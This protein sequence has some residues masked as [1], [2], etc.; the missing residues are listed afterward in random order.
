MAFEGL[1][2]KLRDQWLDLSSKIQESSAFNSARETFESQTPVV[3]KAIL[4]GSGMLFLLFM[5]S[6]PY[7]YIS[8]SNEYL[9]QF[10]ENRGLIQ[11]LL[12]ASR[13][14]KEP[15][16]LPSSSSTD[17][18]RSRVTAIARENQLVPEQIGE[19]QPLPEGHARDLAPPAVHEAGLAVQLKS[20]NLRQVLAVTVALQN[21]GPGTKLLGLDMIQS[22]D[23]THYYDIVARV[24]SFSLPQMSFESEPDRPKAGGRGRPPPKRNN[25]EVE[26]EE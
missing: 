13:A 8:Q 19:M 26:G 15:S 18:L 11:G 9:A 14:A 21:I 24:V 12:R 6:F 17:T 5:L 25:D 4:V 22:A 2:E 1:K 3:Q 16:P 20:L 10:E 7:G 23:Q